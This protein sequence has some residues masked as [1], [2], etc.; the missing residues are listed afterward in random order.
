MF[1]SRSTI[2]ANTPQFQKFFLERSCYFNANLMVLA[3]LT[4][5]RFSLRVDIRLLMLAITRKWS[6]ST[7]APRKVRTSQTFDACLAST[8]M[9][10]IWFLVLWS[11][12][13]QVALWILWLAIWL[14]LG[15]FKPS[16]IILQSF[17]DHDI[18]RWRLMVPTTKIEL[19]VTKYIAKSDDNGNRKRLW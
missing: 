6:E 1:G 4:R 18:L 10:L 3:E 5:S 11:G 16:Y 7:L 13:I 14:A 9:W 19:Y 12:E 15:N 17:H 2:S 8:A